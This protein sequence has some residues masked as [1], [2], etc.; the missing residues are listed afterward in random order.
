MKKYYKLV[1]TLNG[2]LVSY[3][4]YNNA[5]LEDPSIVEYGT[6]IISKPKIAGS[7]LYVFDN[8][9]NVVDF[10]GFE[11]Q[12]WE[13]VV[14]NPKR[15]KQIVEFYDNVVLFWKNRREH[16]TRDTY[17]IATAPKGSIGVDSVKLVKLVEELF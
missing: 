15:I 4:C 16:K 8:L 17:I 10:A 9:Q 7:K 3:N 11:C 6:N 12:V 1:S 13:C 5:T 14:T 2:K